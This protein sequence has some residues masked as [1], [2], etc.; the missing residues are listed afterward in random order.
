MAGAIAGTAILKAQSLT[1]RLHTITLTINNECN[2]KC[3]HCYLQY[4]SN[5]YLINN[6]TI[7]SIFNSDF[8]HLVIVGREPLYNKDSIDIITKIIQLSK[9]HDV[10]LSIVTNGLNLLNIPKNFIK[11]INYIDVS[12]DGGN[13]SYE[14][15]RKGNLR[16][17]IKGIQ[18]VSYYGIHEV[19]ALYTISDKTISN[20]DDF[21]SLIRYFQ[22]PNIMF[23]PYL[24]TEN[25]GFNSVKPIKLHDII[26]KLVNDHFFM[27]SPESFLLIDNYHLEQDKIDSH[28]IEE[29][30]QTNKLHEKIKLFKHDPLFHGIIRVTYDDLVMTPRDSLHTKRY[31]QTNIFASKT[32]LNEVFQLLQMTE[33]EYAN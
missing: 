30:I 31:C 9:E 33:L 10:S 23:S 22:F 3:P 26:E 29:F 17:I 21:I 4:N 8:K 32:N 27:N 24:I 12:F 6:I 14:I 16:R 2:L 19:N 28:E 7:D 18:Y 20:I 13:K 25:H 11:Y 1:E 15:Y 5:K